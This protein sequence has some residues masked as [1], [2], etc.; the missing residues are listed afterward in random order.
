MDLS[1]LV[2]GAFSFLI[3]GAFHVIVLKAEY[4]FSKQI[5]P[6]FLIAGLICLGFSVMESDFVKS[7]M[8][9]VLGFTFLWSIKELFEQ[10]R[11]VAKGWYPRNPK[12]ELYRPVKTDGKNDRVQI[13]N[14][15][16]EG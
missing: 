11:R 10:E 9:S 16:G 8:A 1:G 3:I 6:I 4:H 12:R 14:S 5:W 7:A 13:Q 2:I 15:L